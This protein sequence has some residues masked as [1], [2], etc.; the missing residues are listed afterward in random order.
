MTAKPVSSKL[1]NTEKQDYSS[2][3]LFLG[4][5]G[6]G[7]F[8]TVNKKFPEIWE[9]YKTMKSLDWD[10][11]EFNYSSCVND[12]N[13]CDR[14]TYDM[15]IKTLAWQWE[16]DS[17]ASR[18]SPIVGCFVSSSELWA[19]WQRISDN[20]IV[21]AATYSEI[22]RN[23][24]EDPS[25]ILDEILKVKE[26]LDRMD[27]VVKVLT[28]SHVAAHEYALGKRTAED[29]Y[30]HVFMFAVAMLVLERIQFMSSFAVTFSICDTGMFQPIGK[31]IQKI[32]QDELEVHVEL[33]KAVLRREMKTERGQQCFDRNKQLIKEV[34]DEVVEGELRWNAYLFSEGRELVGI[35][36]KYLDMW[37]LYCA[38]DVYSF[39]GI[40]SE[41]KL[42]AKNPLK[43]MERWLNIGKSQGSPQEEDIAQYKVNVMRRD[44]EGEEF[45]VDF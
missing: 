9:L 3:S 29:T 45:E 38:K 34:I 32:A 24:F 18:I 5:G 43:F 23:S 7:L 44:D 6:N 40:E 25:E 41:H 10:E 13:T 1:F 11:N 19:A 37:T 28:D 27:K 33:D 4:D 36:N 22:V 20:E 21:H 39:F 17:V 42:P 35:N 15:M 30:D 2:P 16:A 8:D 31:A 14:A 12:F 26:S